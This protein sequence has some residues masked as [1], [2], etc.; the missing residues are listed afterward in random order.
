MAL[1]RNLAAASTIASLLALGGGLAARRLGPGPVRLEV[2]AFDGG[3][4]AGEWW[5]S[6][7]LDVDPQATTDGRT[8]FYVR[9]A[10]AGNR[11]VFPVSP[12]GGP[13]RFTLRGSTSVRSAIGVF[14]GGQRAGEMLVRPGPWG[15]HTLELAAPAAGSAPLE[16]S[17][18]L[19]PLPQVRGDHIEDPELYVDYVEVEAPRGFSLTP[20]AWLLVALCPL[21]TFA[22]SMGVG[23][24]PRAALLATLLAAAGSAVLARMAPMPFLLAA[25]RLLPLAAACGLLARLALSR[26]RL[27]AWERAS[28]AG[29]VG[30]GTLFHGS[31]VFFP[32][33]NPPDIDI[34]VRRTL[35]LAG[36]PLGYEALM[37]Y[38]SQLPT[39]SQDLGQ[40]TAALGERTLIPYSPLPYLLYYLAH[41]AGLDLYWAMS[42][43]NAAIA[44]LVTPLLWAAGARLWGRGA[45]WLAALLYSLD[46]AVWHHMGRSH[47]PAVLGGALGTAA[48]LYLAVRAEGLDAPRRA[49]M[50]GA[51]LGVAVLG[52][53][54]LVVLIGLFGIALLLLVAVDARGLTPASRRGLAAALV[55]GGLLAGGLFYFHYVPGLLLGARGIE[56]EP[57]LFPGKTFLVFHN[58]SRQSLRIWVLGYWVP[59]LAGLLAAP[60]AFSRMRPSARPVALAWL[61]D[62]AA[63][64][65]LKEP[66][67]LPKLLRWAKEDQFL[68]P[69]LCLLVAG[70][71]A[72]LPRAWMRWGGAALCLGTAAW[73]ELRDFAHHANS[74]RL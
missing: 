28:L 6:R 45:A 1:S 39:A 50:A 40:A 24:P 41:L 27:A 44:M 52:Y 49:A 67:L 12:A 58:E 61:L 20:R 38:G 46:L 23:A 21:V 59:L 43:L 2:G 60:F 13:L 70:A 3:H 36:V 35:D 31:V 56:A 42:A 62:W 25:P 16:V 10:P 17:L 69:L 48:L 14:L 34:H 64:M 55:I 51:I 9:A 37:R 53:S 54:S 30:A 22:F 15:R 5:R 33:H 11:F 74:L 68:S 71:V 73:L 66:F 72:S 57:D 32:D 4:V 29:L 65:L 7:R 8:S 19:R 47:A 18:A 26:G 63:L